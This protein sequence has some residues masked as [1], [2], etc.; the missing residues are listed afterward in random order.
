MTKLFTQS[1]SKFCCQ[2]QNSKPN[3][4]FLFF[5]AGYHHH[6]KYQY[7]FLFLSFF[8]SPF[9]LSLSLSS[10]MC[11]GCQEGKPTPSV[12]WPNIHLFF[13]VWIPVSGTLMKHAK[14]RWNTKVRMRE[15]SRQ[16]TTLRISL[17]PYLLMNLSKTLSP[18]IGLS[19]S[20]PHL[21]P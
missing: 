15:G 5:L 8:L 20:L 6:H 10:P 4:I 7:Q 19:Q 18:Y 3:T 21:N 14:S 13:W 17:L 12:W 16:G 1:L 11:R 2:T 9:S